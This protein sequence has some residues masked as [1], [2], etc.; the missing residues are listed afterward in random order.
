MILENREQL[1]TL[2]GVNIVVEAG[3]GTGKTT[4]L[5]DRLCLAVLAQGTPVEKLVALTF[6]EKAAAEIKTRFIFKLQSLVRAI[7]QKQED[8]SLE[9]LRHTF[10]VKDDLLLARA[11][12]ALARM[13]RASVGTIHGFCAEI[14]KAY[15]L[16]AGLA[17]NAQIDS[18]QCAARLFDA[19]WNSFLDEQLGPAAPAAQEWKKVLKEVSLPELKDFAQELCSGK[20]EAYDYFAHRDML[21]GIC[22]ERARRA[23]ELASPYIQPGKKIRNAELALQLAALSLRRTAAFLKSTPVP[24]APQ[25]EM[26]AFPDKCYKD[27]E[28]PLFEEARAIV[29]FAS[30]T[31]PEKQQ[32]FLDA[33]RLIKDVTDAVRTEYAREG[34]LS[35]DDLIVKTRNLLQNNLYVRRL[36]KEKFDVLFIDEF[37]DTD[38]VQGELLLFLAEEKTSSAARWQDVR[39]APGKLFVVG[40][41][42]QSIYRFR[43]ADITAYELFT[44]LILKQGGVKHFLQKNFRSAPEIIE[45]ANSVCSRAMIEQTSFQPAYVPIFT[46]KTARC[47]AS[48]WLFITV[49]E[50]QKP[51]ADAFRDNQ[52]ERIADW[53]SQNVGRLTLADGRKLAYKDIALLTRAATTAGPFTDALRRR[54]IAFNVETDK[55]FYRKQEVNDFLNFLRAASDPQD[56]TA[57]AGVLRSPLGGMTDEEIYQLVQRGE[58]NLFAKTADE[59]ASRCYA[60]LKDFGARAGHRALKDLLEDVLEDTFLPEACA[61]SYEGEQ[62]LANLRRLASMAQGYAAQG[63]ASLSQFL[64]EIQTLLEEHPDRLTAPAPDDALDAVCVMTVH[65]SKGLEFPVVILADLSKRDTASSSD[66]AAHIFSWQYNMHGLR[67]GKVC[68]VNLAFLEEE[69][70]KHDRCEEVRVLYVALTRAKEKMLL[71]ADAR[72]GAQKAAA[73]FVAAGLFPDGEQQPAFLQDGSLSVPVA[74][75]AYQEPDAFR[76]QHLSVGAAAETAREVAAWREAY[77]RRKTRYEDF[78]AHNQKRAPSELAQEADS[79]TEAQRAGAE[80]GTV[81]H[82][83]LERLLSRRENDLRQAVHQ[84]AAAAGAPQRADEAQTVLEAFVKSP[85][86]A[87][88]QSCKTLAWEMPFSFVTEQG[89]VESGVM[90]IV[91]ERADGSIWVADYKTDRIAPGQEAAVLEEKYRAQLGVYRKAAQRLFP[92]KKVRCSAVF[93]RTFAAADL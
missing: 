47:G 36:L 39:L 44:D 27:W 80:L 43:G 35:F 22:L 85:L 20:I 57:L 92:D 18:G 11:E 40:D 55:N 74:Y 61:A 38:P 71:T 17:P 59:K 6:T 76:Y 29:S 53:I 10:G 24:P 19:R 68:D 86:F 33:Y 32:L 89:A 58:L 81:C 2:L 79:L 50:G 49:Q 48:S 72:V 14:L 41:P 30:K 21:A 75:A 70:K 16:E 13:D 25:P 82:R 45:T 90:D 93:V 66:P 83:A 73:P 9:R 42:K 52:A 87:E 62:T 23:E 26:P 65:K 28:E 31:T 84:A 15:P 88:L 7:K 63:G 56:R 4:L 51:S 64:T 91:L 5:I 1:Q 3:A 78:L 60:L 67:V 12:A 54:G 46:D 77:A 69:Q 37:Q 34:I 8:A